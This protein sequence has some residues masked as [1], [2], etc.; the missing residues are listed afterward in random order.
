M[1]VILS[2][3]FFNSNIANREDCLAVIDICRQTNASFSNHSTS[4][5]R[6]LLNSSFCS[7]GW[8]D[9]IKIPFS[10]MAISYQKGRI[11]VC[12]QFGNTC[13]TYA[14]MLKMQHLFD[15]DGID[16]GIIILP[17]KNGS[18]FLSS[19]VCSLD[20]FE[21]DLNIFRDIINLPLLLIGVE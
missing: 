19:G 17:T 7:Q 3:T 11:G 16:F 9:K 2:R 5:V 6:E 8:I 1:L 4:I 13:R 21:E 10:N 14:D 18:N 15:N 20:K 12:V